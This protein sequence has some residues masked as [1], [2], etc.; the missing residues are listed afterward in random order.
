MGRLSLGRKKSDDSVDINM[1]PMV[2]MTFLL[3]IF[4][5]VTTTFVK[6]SGVEVNRPIASTTES[7]ENT[8]IVIGVTKEGMIYI[9]NQIIDV[10]SVRSRMERFKSEMPEG[11]VVIT[12]DKDSLFG[13][14]IDVL[15][16]VR[17]AGIKNVVVAATKE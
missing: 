16:Q 7:K 17:L 9:E 5:L 10:R 6:E 8:N 11:N 12:A 2:D 14:A 15:D 13:V 3:L 4:F 1:S